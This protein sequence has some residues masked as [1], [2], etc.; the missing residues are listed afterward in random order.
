MPKIDCHFRD[1]GSYITL[2]DEWKGKHQLRRETAVTKLMEREVRYPATI[3]NF[4]VGVSMLD[5]W[6]LPGMPANPDEWNVGEVPNNVMIWVW[7]TVDAS[8]NAS[9]IVPKKN[10]NPLSTGQ[11]EMQAMTTGGSSEMEPLPPGL[12]TLDS[13]HGTNGTQTERS[14]VPA[15]G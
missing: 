4:I 8:Y 14:P 10:L 5:D 2:P 7:A 3:H 6:S 15:D 12:E 13:R 11:P 9:F 1:D